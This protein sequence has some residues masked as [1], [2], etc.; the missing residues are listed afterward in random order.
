MAPFEM[1]LVVENGRDRPQ[2]IEI[3]R[4]SRT[5]LLAKWITNVR[6]KKL[7][8]NRS[9]KRNFRVEAVLAHALHQ[10]EY[11]LRTTQLSRLS[12][13]LKLRKQLLKGVDYGACGLYNMVEEE[14]EK[15]KDVY[16]R[17]TTFWQ[18]KDL[19]E[20]LVSLDNFLVQL[21]EIKPVVHR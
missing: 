16:A 18:E 20:D 9:P 4:P 8:C 15:S 2:E 21:K 12:R 5:E 6:H 11:E 19:Y 17:Q 7:K 1:N 10:A 13:W 3:G 14:L